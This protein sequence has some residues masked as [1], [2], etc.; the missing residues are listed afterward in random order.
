MSLMENRVY[1]ITILL[2][3]GYTLL[4]NLMYYDLSII[5]VWKVNSSGLIIILLNN[6]IINCD[7]HIGVTSY[8]YWTACV[9]CRAILSVQR[10]HCSY[11]ILAELSQLE[12]YIMCMVTLQLLYSILAVPSQRLHQTLLLRMMGLTQGNPHYV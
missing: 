10:W 6:W 7:V 2:Y 9:L 8:S 1:I 4:F 11:F 12:G 3:G 5:I